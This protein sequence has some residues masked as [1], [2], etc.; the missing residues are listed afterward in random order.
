MTS[1]PIAVEVVG[2]PQVLGFKTEAK[3]DFALHSEAVVKAA[4]CSDPKPRSL[5][6]QWGSL[7]LIEGTQ[8]SF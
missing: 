7:R 2:K 4:F 1:D 8:S 3:Q 6:W 5:M